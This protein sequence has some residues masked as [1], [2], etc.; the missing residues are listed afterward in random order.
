M[1]LFCT[2]LDQT[3]IYSYKHEIG[4]RKRCVELYEGRE[5]SYMTDRTYCL[6]SEL[7]KYA[8]IVPVTTR[9]VAQYQ[10]IQLGI[11]SIRYALVCNGGVLLSDGRNDPA[12][13]QRSLELAED[14][15]QEL[16]AAVRFL[17]LE[18][19]RTLEVRL[20]EGLFV[21]TKC[22]NPQDV[23]RRL[24][25]E[26][27]AQE[28]VRGGQE[29]CP[30][31]VDV[32]SNGEKVYV[33]PARL[34]KGT[35][36]ARLRELVGADQVFAAGDSAFDL[37]MLVQADAAA[38]P[39]GCGFHS[40]PGHVRVMDGKGVFSEEMLRYALGVFENRTLGERI[41]TPCRRPFQKVKKP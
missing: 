37:P 24:K 15:R 30:C 33:V 12:W 16:A 13:Y 23:V 20:I 34:N 19:Y 22:S 27:Q 29:Q 26:L 32:F 40:L 18:Q 4:S 35:A 6:L 5:V 17:E 10:R 28:A 25:K 11:E 36:V 3:L 2:D 21:F 9:S 39:A 14:S 31:A 1:V 38:A 41:G 8:C 7:S